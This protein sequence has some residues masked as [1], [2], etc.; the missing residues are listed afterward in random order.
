MR[1]FSAAILSV[2]AIA[3][4]AWA[5]WQIVST[6]NQ[7][8]SIAGVEYCRLN[9]EN[10]GERAVLQAAVVS[11]KSTRLEVIDNPGGNDSL[12]EAM[13]RE[14]CIAGVNGGYFDPAFKPIGL[15]VSNET[16]ISPLTRAR[17]LKG[18]LC[19]SVRGIEIVRLGEFSRNR[20]LDSA[21]ESGPF[22]VDLG[23][24]VSGLDQ[25]RRARRTFAAVGRH[26]RAMLG[27]CSELTLD[28]L[29]ILLSSVSLREDFKIWRALNL[30]GGSSSAFWFQRKDG[31][32]ISVPEEKTVRDF[33]GIAAK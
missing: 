31:S 18:V 33:V 26:G 1:K 21:I 9:A 32:A 20:K 16:I 5:D 12:A 28:Q 14:N 8:S 15:L 25:T 23:R 29:A 13:K 10:S 7:P 2:A 4:I 11:A 22:L 19:S 27:I 17:L 30:D 6:S 3:Q 24:H